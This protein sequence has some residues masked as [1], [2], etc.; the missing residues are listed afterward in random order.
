MTL[1][2]TFGSVFST[3]ISVVITGP[4]KEP[5]NHS[6]FRPQNPSTQTLPDLFPQPSV[7]PHHVPGELPP[8]YIPGHFEGW[9][10]EY[11]HL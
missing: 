5:P 2:L 7:S 4:V 8:F 9:G 11:V 3:K 10:T 6:I 1:I